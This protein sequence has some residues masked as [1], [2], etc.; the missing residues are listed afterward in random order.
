MLEEKLNKTEHDCAEQSRAVQRRDQEEVIEMG[1]RL[2]MEE[3]VRNGNEM[4]NGMG[5]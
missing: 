5:W 1:M 4:R 2:E 3:K